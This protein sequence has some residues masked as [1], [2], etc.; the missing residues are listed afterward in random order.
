V[1]TIPTNGI[2]ILAKKI[3]MDNLNRYD[4]DVLEL[5]LILDIR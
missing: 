3:G 1:S 4:L 5:L 2:A